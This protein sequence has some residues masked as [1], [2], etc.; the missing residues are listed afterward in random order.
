MR[1]KKA[2]SGGGK[3]GYPARKKEL[4]EKGKKF[5]GDDATGMRSGTTKKDSMNNREGGIRRARKKEPRGAARE[6]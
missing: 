5:K 2:A 4:G 3:N 6:G 1:T